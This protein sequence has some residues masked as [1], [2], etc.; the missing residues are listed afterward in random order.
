MTFKQN[1]AAAASDEPEYEIDSFELLWEQHKGK[2]IGG[3]VALI[4]IV[5][6]V[7]GWIIVTNARKSAAEAALAS[8]KSA[9]DYRAVIDHYGSSPVAGDASLLLAKSLRGGKKY[10]EAN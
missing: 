10:A 7:F 5:V 4:V 2:V 9:A 3:A 1:P 6:A 8:A